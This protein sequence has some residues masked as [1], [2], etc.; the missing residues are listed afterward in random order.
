VRKVAIVSAWEQV[1][2]GEIRGTERLR[3]FCGWIVKVEAE[4][5]TAICFVPDPKQ[6]WSLSSNA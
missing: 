5:N 1:E 3:V 4:K 6:E 2:G